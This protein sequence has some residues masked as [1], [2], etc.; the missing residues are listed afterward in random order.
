MSAPKLSRILSVFATRLA[1]INGAGVFDTCIGERVYRSQRIPTETDIP[2]VLVYLN[3]RERSE[4]ARGGR[5]IFDGTVIVEGYA[6]RTSDD[7]GTAIS[8]V[9]DIQ[10]AVETD[11]TLDDLLLISNNGLQCISEEFVYPQDSDSVVGGR[12]EYSIPH[13][14]IP[15][16]PEKA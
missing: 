14:R 2:C 11:L 3:S 9:S 12:V 8:I 1:A 4:Q 7:E 6:R 16:D 13:L 15:G 10:Q 5:A